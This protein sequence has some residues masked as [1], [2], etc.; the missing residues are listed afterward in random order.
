[1]SPVR[2]SESMAAMQEAGIE[3]LVEAGPGEV[4]TRL[5]KRSAP[6]VEAIAVNSPA[7]AR[8]LAKKVSES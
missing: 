8:E 3:M 1:M 5:A 2:W 7:D 4:L 6:G